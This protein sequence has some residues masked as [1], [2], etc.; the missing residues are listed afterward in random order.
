MS[1]SLFGSS[2]SLSVIIISEHCVRVSVDYVLMNNGVTCMDV[3]EKL[4]FFVSCLFNYVCIVRYTW[5]THN[6]SRSRPKI[7]GTDNE[8]PTFKNRKRL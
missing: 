3:S 7:V 1:F 8:Q 5:R 2:H 6:W 4:V